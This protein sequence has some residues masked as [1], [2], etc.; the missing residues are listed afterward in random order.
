[1]LLNREALLKKEELKIEKVVFDNGDFVYVREMTGR[2][3]DR[4]EQSLVKQIKDE[5]GN[6]QDY[7]RSLEDFR[8]KLAV[9]TLCD[10]K[11]ILIMKPDDFGMLSQNMSAA[12]L[13]GII[14]AAQRLNR[15]S[16][17][18]RKVLVKNSEGAQGA[19]SASGSVKK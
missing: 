19:D 11:G 1:M 16:E 4:F 9:N 6:I 13:E 12:R 14:N 18:D 8:A 5:R 7:E 17:E 3:R 2:E 10:E 15:I